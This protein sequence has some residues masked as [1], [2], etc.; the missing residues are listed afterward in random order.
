MGTRPPPALP[1]ALRRRECIRRALKIREK[2]YG[3]G[4]AEVGATLVALAV[5]FGHNRRPKAQVAA[6]EKALDILERELGR[7][8]ATTRRCRT[9][10]RKAT[11]KV[12][13][14][15]ADGG[16]LARLACCFGPRGDRARVNPA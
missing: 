16:L 5:A 1:L 4:H 11:R 8:H 6:L 10:L 12:T 2:E 9:S 13:Q 14:A 7:D 15:R 3:P